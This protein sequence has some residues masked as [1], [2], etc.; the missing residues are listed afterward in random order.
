MSAGLGGIA[1]IVPKYPTTE[2]AINIS[3]YVYIVLHFGTLV[4]TPSVTCL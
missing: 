1:A 3:I 2:Q 4:S